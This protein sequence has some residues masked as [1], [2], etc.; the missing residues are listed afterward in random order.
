MVVE[1][2]TEPDT[3]TVI[4]RLAEIIER[5]AEEAIENEDIFKI[6]LSGKFYYISFIHLYNYSTIIQLSFFNDLL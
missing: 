5:F 2:L 6:G 3:P 1:I 4:K